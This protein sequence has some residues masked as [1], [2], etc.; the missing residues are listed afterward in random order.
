LGLFNQVPRANAALGNPGANDAAGGKRPL[1]NMTPT[2]ILKDGEP[3]AGTG[4]LGSGFIPSVVLNVT[5]NLIEYDLP[6][7]QAVDAPRL[8]IQFASGAAQLN[9]GFDHLITPLRDMGH[10]ARVTFGGCAE[11]LNRMSQP[12]IF[13]GNPTVGS[14]GSFGVDLET[15]G[16]RGGVDGTRLPDAATVVVERS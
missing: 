14:T 4:T 12:P 3:F 10:I 15:F 2:L 11:N 13:N 16:L 1:G 9:V 8:W 6:L 7:Q 5:L